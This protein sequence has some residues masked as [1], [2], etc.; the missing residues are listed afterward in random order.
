MNNKFRLI[1]MNDFIFK[2]PKILTHP[3]LWGC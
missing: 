2:T 1:S 3:H